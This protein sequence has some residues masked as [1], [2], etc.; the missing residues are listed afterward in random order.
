MNTLL[1]LVLPGKK[2]PAGVKKWAM[3]SLLDALYYSI[4]LSLQVLESSGATT[5]FFTVALQSLDK[6]TRVHEKKVAIVAFLSILNSDPNSLPESIKAGLPQLMVGLIQ[7]LKSLPD[8]MKKR[9]DA[10]DAFESGDFDGFEDED[11]LADFSKDH[12]GE[13]N[14]VR[15]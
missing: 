7:V 1:P 5:A 8:A 14:S 3:I 4:S 2:T 10:T 12:D 6:L 9:R 11:D 15:A 13:W